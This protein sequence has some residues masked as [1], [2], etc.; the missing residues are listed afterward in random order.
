MSKK[1]IHELAKDYEMSGKDMAAK[2][3]R[4]GFSQVK[5]HMTA[6]DDFEVMQVQGILEAHGI[7][8]GSAAAAVE[9][10]DPSDDE[11]GGLIVRKKKKKKPTVAA[12]VPTPAP[13]PEAEIE[14]ASEP[15]S[16]VEGAAEVAV[17]TA[18]EVAPEGAVE[19]ADANP[20]VQ[21]EE[22]ESAEIAPEPETVP[23]EAPI[24]EA[25]IA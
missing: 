12:V 13:E 5:S 17:E 10:P 14:Q 24:L 20:Q 23:S 21:V 18:P 15:A 22:S 4:L 19:V 7:F 11:L 16:T 6:L 8:S 25:V 3:K 2:L 1:R 9:T